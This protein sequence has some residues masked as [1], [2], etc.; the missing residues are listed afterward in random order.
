[1]NGPQDLGGQMGFGPINPEPEST[2]PLFHSPWERRALAVSLATGALGH[3][4]TDR[5]RFTRE[6][7]SPAVYYSS[8]YY[9]IWIRALINLLHQEGLVSPQELAEGRAI[10]PA[11]PTKRPP[12]KAEL[13]APT[14][15]KGSPYRRESN[16][17]PQFVVGQSILTINH[18]PVGH[19]RLP[20][21]ARGRRG[22]IESVRGVFVYPD[23]MAHGPDNPQW[24]YTVVFDATELWGPSA[25]PHSTVSVDAFEPYLKAVS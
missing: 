2:E 25:D 18:H 9:E 24:C 14:M 10:D 12:L 17:T 6:S 21:Y 22:R 8:S 1:M 5:S 11:A 4:T 3:W 23:A 7:L 20:R 13:V 15:A 19:T 16:T